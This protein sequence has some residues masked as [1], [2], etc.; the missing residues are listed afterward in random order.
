MCS[1]DTLKKQY[2]AFSDIVRLEILKL[3]TENG[4]MCVCDLQK[5]LGISQPNISFH[6]KLLK[7]AKCVTLEKQGKWNFYSVNDTNP[8]I[9][10]NLSF[11]SE[12]QSVRIA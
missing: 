9:K 5:A 6:L 11:I 4:P 10:A 8:Y 3:L 2:A 7:E 12:A 1:I